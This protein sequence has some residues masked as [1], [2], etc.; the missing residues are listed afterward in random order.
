M[1]QLSLFKYISSTSL[2][3]NI[4]SGV[5]TSKVSSR[6]S[7]N[8]GGYFIGG[9]INASPNNNNVVRFLPFA[10]EVVNNLHSTLVNPTTTSSGTSGQAI[11]WRP[12]VF[13]N[14]RVKGFSWGGWY[15]DQAVLVFAQANDFGTNTWYVIPTA[16]TRTY[17]PQNWGTTN[18]G[19]AGYIMGGYIS[20]NTTDGANAVEKL[21]Y[22]TETASLATTWTGN[23]GVSSGLC[24]NGT[25]ALYQMG[26]SVGQ[27]GGYADTTRISKC[28][29]STD[30][31]SIIAGT[32]GD[33]RDL[34]HA[35][36]SGASGAAYCM[37]GRGGNGTAVDK[38]PFSTETCSVLAS[39][40]TYNVG[41][42]FTASFAN[43]GTAIYAG[44]G[45]GG[46]AS[47]AVTI[48]KW[49]TS[50]DA[51]QAVITG[52]TSSTDSESNAY[53]DTSSN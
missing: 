16:A 44:M 1:A 42:G 43:H 53:A 21:S 28:V 4:T 29:Y 24:H 36:Q 47:A 40:H 26:G 9:R 19:T 33:S 20:Q 32:I 3:S 11:L 50:T 39:G 2:V 13:A 46:S 6:G 17:R 25:T 37:N 52:L 35:T 14:Y 31:A 49:L 8:Y 48:D 51:R 34:H 5:L 30:T 10:T 27:A 7:V 12:A 45:S 23:Y 22:S 38:M 41:N 15:A 18:P